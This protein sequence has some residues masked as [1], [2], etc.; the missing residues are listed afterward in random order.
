M[1]S[2]R[3]IIAALLNWAILCA[4]AIIAYLLSR[5]HKTPP[6]RLRFIFWAVVMIT[7]AA[8]GRLVLRLLD[9]W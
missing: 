6:R 8:T 9:Y 2:Q 3:C 4:V 5:K 1:A 7:L